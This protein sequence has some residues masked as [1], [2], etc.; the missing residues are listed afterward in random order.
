M[1]PG[2]QFLA[3]LA[4]AAAGIALGIDIVLK[5]ATGQGSWTSIGIDATLTFIPFGKTVKLLTRGVRAT[6]AL[7]RAVG[8]TVHAGN[9]THA[10]FSSMFGALEHVNAPRYHLG[11]PWQNNCQSCVV[12]VDRTLA[13][14][15]RIALPRPESPL[16]PGHPD[17]GSDWKWPSGVMRE[18]NVSRPK[19]VGSYD[20]ISNRLLAAGPG[21]RGIVHGY[22][23]TPTGEYDLGHVFNVINRDG[24]IYYLDG[25]IGSWARLL[26]YQRLE[27]L[28][29]R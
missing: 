29:G 23:L 21:S 14:R 19:I 3:P 28:M 24:T 13:G 16:N 25:Q 9:A 26:P 10:E 6:D 8:S 11:W 18:A 22:N 4:M 2:L 7:G 17:I 5:L 1:V 15:P 12:A 20:E 27:L